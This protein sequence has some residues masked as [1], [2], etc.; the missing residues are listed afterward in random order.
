MSSLYWIGLYEGRDSKK[1]EWLFQVDLV[2]AFSYCGKRVAGGSKFS[3][4]A[5]HVALVL[6]WHTVLWPLLFDN[7]MPVFYT[8]AISLSSLIEAIVHRSVSHV[9]AGA[10]LGIII[11]VT[12]FV[13]VLQYCVGYWTRQWVMGLVDDYGPGSPLV[14]QYCGH[15][16]LFC[17]LV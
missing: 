17:L 8:L 11:G 7:G 3:H 13:A 16:S 14:E 15:H 1:W 6:T 2:P 9:P 10:I 12:V 4:A 5:S